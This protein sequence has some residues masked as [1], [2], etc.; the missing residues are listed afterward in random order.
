MFID[1]EDHPELLFALPDL[2]L[3]FQAGRLGVDE[4]DLVGV[5]RAGVSVGQVLG[6]GE[7][8]HG[9]IVIAGRLEG[10][11]QIRMRADQGFAEQ[12]VVR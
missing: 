11:A 3:G 8:V 12:T 6:P 5:H 1:P 7:L 4:L 9:L 10:C 2:P